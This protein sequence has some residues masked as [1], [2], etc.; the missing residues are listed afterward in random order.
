MIAVGKPLA[1]ETVD[2]LR[3][4]FREN[5]FSE[6]AL[7]GET[8]SSSTNGGFWIRDATKKKIFG[9]IAG[10]Y[11]FQGENISFSGEHDGLEV[12]ATFAR[13]SGYLDVTGAVRNSRERK[14]RCVDLKFVLPINC[15][16]WNWGNDPSL[17]RIIEKEVH[18]EKTGDQITVYPIACISSTNRDEGI[19]IAVPPTSP[20]LFETGAGKDG[21]FITFKIGLSQST[22]PSNESSFHFIIYRHDPQWGFRSSLQ[23]YYQF[24]QNPFF[25]RRAIKLGAWGWHHPSP[26]ELPNADLYAFHESAGETWKIKDEG[27][28]G[29]EHEGINQ[30]TNVESFVRLTRVD[31]DE[32]LGIYSLPY[33]IVGQRQV[34]HLPKMPETKDETLAAFETWTTEQP[35]IFQ[36]PGP[37]VSFRDVSQLKEIIRN[38][39]LHDEQHRPDILMRQYL[40]NTLTFPLNPNPRLFSDGTNLTIAKYTL[41]E[42]LPMLFNASKRIDGCYV[43]SLGRWPGYYNFRTEHF[44]YASLPLTYSGKTPQPCIWNLQ[45]HAEYL[46]ELSRRLH[47]QNKIV[48]A[49]GVHPNRVMLGFYVDVLG[50]EGLPD[51]TKSGFY[52]KRVAAYNKPFCALNGRDSTKPRVWNSCLFLGIFAGARSKEGQ[53]LERKFLPIIIRLNEAG[54]QPITLA[55]SDSSALGIERW[56]DGHGKPVLFSFLNRSQQKLVTT[57]RVNADKLFMSDSVF[58]NL[59][60]GKKIPSQGQGDAMTITIEL[61]PETS[62]AI[63]MISKK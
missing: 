54:W 7:E 30:A 10:H 37:S 36:S 52:S 45:S 33:T 55:R 27:M 28:H 48:F 42:Y 38:S 61:E 63:E 6:V 26:S 21:L 29:Y 24:F 47:E 57:V 58:R 51:F 43:D 23:S 59:L 39:S 16:G 31:D 50:E 18:G 2:A 35:M 49:N 9:Q 60:S 1:V 25:T 56:G 8:L 32:K 20:T 62:T 41:D 34:Y 19:S 44:K 4:R 5:E 13:K 14:D 12:S 46:M 22:Q 15:Q 3:L 17:E 40:G 53:K 11:S